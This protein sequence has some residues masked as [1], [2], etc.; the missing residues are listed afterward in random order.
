MK[1]LL[2]AF[3][4]SFLL[5]LPYKFCFC[6]KYTNFCMALFAT[7]KKVQILAIILKLI[8]T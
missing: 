1:F 5:K 3:F 4:A 2:N 8:L 6:T 7:V